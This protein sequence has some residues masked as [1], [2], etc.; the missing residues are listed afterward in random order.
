[1]SRAP[2]LVAVAAL[3]WAPARARAAEADAYDA[4]LTRAIA[5]KERALDVNE[6]QR[7]EEALRLFE[8]AGALKQTRECAYEIGFA[9]DR[10]HRTDLAVESY[11]AAIELGLGGAPRARAQAYVSAN[12]AGLARVDVRGPPGTRIRVGGIERGKLPLRRPLVLFPAVAELELSFAAGETATYA[13][14]LRA[15]KTEVVEVPPPAAAAAAAPAP[16][17]SGLGPRASDLGEE[18]RGPKPDVRSPE[19]RSPEAPGLNWADRG[20]APPPPAAVSAR[21]WWLAGA[22]A[23]IA[24]AAAVLVPVS[25]SR[26]DSSRTALAGECVDL[27]VNDQCLA[28]PGHREQAQS[29]ADDIATWKN[30]RTGAWVGVGVGLAAVVAGA[31]LRLSDTGV[32]GSHAGTG[33]GA[34]LDHRAGT[35]LALLTWTWGI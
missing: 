31:V 4:A 32:A 18:A 16:A 11:E 20:P 1:L 28:K 26:V 2:I 21:G 27:V 10:L 19:A 29:Y 15:G 30:V 33:L 25:G 5:A 6:P 24:V 23:A 17:L 12:A 34:A 9:A 22:G 7:W 35:N 3:L 13:V 14:H 8:E